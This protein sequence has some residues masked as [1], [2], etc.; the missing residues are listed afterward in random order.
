MQTPSTTVILLVDDD[1]LLVKSLTFLLRQ[2]GYEVR[3]AATAAEAIESVRAAPPDL[4]ILDIGLPDLTGV[5]A[6]RRIRARWTGPIIMLTG[7]RQETDKVIGLDAGADDYLVKPVGSNEL[8]A[9]VRAGVRR[10]RTSAPDAGASGAITVG[11]IEIDTNARIVSVGDRRVQLSAREYDLLLLLAERAGQAVSGNSSSIASGVWISS[12]ISAPWTYTFACCA[13]SSS[14][15][16]STPGI[17]VRCAGSAIVWM[18]AT[19]IHSLRARLILVF[20][21]LTLLSVALFAIVTAGVLERML[22]RYL[23]DG[24]ATQAQLIRRSSGSRS[25]VGECRRRA[26]RAVADRRGDNRA[27]ARRGYA[28]SA[29][30]CFR[31]SGSRAVGAAIRESRA[32]PGAR[33]P[34]RAHRPRPRKSVWGGA[35]RGA[36][37]P[38]RGSRG[39]GSASGIPA[40]GLAAIHRQ[41]E[42]GNRCWGP[43]YGCHRRGARRG[44]R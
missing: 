34:L 22:L 41:P 24:V 27:R 7:R 25:G 12:A 11:Q 23:S 43:G 8:L 14:L 20:G 17:S 21:G 38:G 9:R 35:V 3:S 13:R 19:V 33:G 44:V 32:P 15:I 2:D 36:A 4:V 6:C 1:A 10:W 40:R 29:S 39:G 26:G 37:R 5:E 18:T 31:T 30:G 42:S 28:P 16:P